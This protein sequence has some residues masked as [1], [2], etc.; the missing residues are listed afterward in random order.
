MATNSNGQLPAELAS[1]KHVKHELSCTKG[2]IILRGSRIVI[3]TLLQARVVELAHGGHQGIVKTKALIRSKVWFPG[4]DARVEQA[5]KVCVECQVNTDRENYEPMKPSPMPPGPWH[6]IS[7]DY[8]GPMDDGWYWHVTH[9]E[10]SRWFAVDRVKSTSEDDLEPVLEKLFGTFGAPVV[11]KSDNG[12]PYQSYRFKEFAEKWGFTHRKI[13][14]LW[15]RANAGAESVMK[16]LGK[17]LKT[18]KAGNIDKNKH[19]QEFL[20]RYRETPHSTTKVP[21]ALL[22]MGFSRHSGLPQIE[23]PWSS[24]ALDKWHK[25]AQMN[26]RI[27]KERMKQEYDHRMH[28]N[29]LQGLIKAQISPKINVKVGQ[30]PI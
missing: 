2:G 16:K 1:F 11:F 20:R 30:R 12:S 18:A 14:P 26:D 7:G 19:L 22:L 24:R 8:F 13:S 28:R 27:A 17:V 5:I 21:P 10:Y 25:L 6:T 29:R 4:I 23:A 15:P 9:D 3:P